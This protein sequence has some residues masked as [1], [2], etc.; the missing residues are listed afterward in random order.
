MSESRI[1]REKFRRPAAS[2][3]WL[4]DFS[5][6][7]HI[8]LA[9]TRLEDGRLLFGNRHLGLMLGIPVE[10]ATGKDFRPFY[11]DPVAY[12]KLLL[13]LVQSGGVPEMEIGARRHDGTPL[14]VVVS[15]T[16]VTYAGDPGCILA[17]FSDLSALRLSEKMATLGTLTAGIAHE[18]NNPAAAT[19]RAA[20]QL[21]D[22][23][24][25]LQEGYLRITALAV[26][27]AGREALRNIEEEARA[28]AS[29]PA[30]LDALARS[31]RET[32]VEDW[33]EE[34]GIPDQEDLAPSL[35]GQGLQAAALSDLAG[36]FKGDALSDVLH[37]AASAYQVYTLT[38][39]IR[40]GSGRISEIVR[41]LKG[42][43]FPGQAQA[44]PVDIHQGLDS[45]LV[46]LRSKIKGGVTV[47]RMY[48]ENMPP[49]M[50]YGSE[51]NQVWTNLLDNAIDAMHGN[52]EITI[53]TR[54]EAG[55]TV[56]DIED[57]GPGIPPAAQ[58]RI[59]DPFFTTKEPGQGIGLGLSTSHR[60]V[61]EKHKGEIRVESR[62]GLTRFTV[63]LPVVPPSA[64]GPAPGRSA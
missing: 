21:G 32:A 20:V 41:A 19:H 38:Y 4:N 47:H 39:L 14:T 13:S 48:G 37:W 50:A 3:D 46:I 18:L 55:W 7:L 27:P 44:Q 5:E 42:Y 25:R 40:Q 62:P 45:T 34:H 51:L 63:R 16:R 52:G 61:T 12:E 31:D 56:V 23:F 53:R 54:N 60:I 10:E 8:P 9:V 28:Q 33:L 22:A 2:V 35:A 59:F 15:L 36:V 64:A 58:S 30:D 26:T 17:A 24:A 29:R 6:T 49:V 43:S 1:Q 11:T 57:N